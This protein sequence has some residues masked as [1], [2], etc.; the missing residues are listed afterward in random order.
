MWEASC[1]SEVAQ[2]VELL[3]WLNLVTLKWASDGYLSRSRR[4]LEA[5]QS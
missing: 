1:E 2:A 5:A 4:P 3:R